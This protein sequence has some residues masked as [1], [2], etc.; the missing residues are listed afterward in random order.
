MGV[1]SEIFKEKIEEMIQA[2]RQAAK[3]E[4]WSE[5]KELLEEKFQLQERYIRETDFENL[6]LRELLA[7]VGAKISVQTEPNATFSHAGIFIAPSEISYVTVE[8]NKRFITSKY[9]LSKKIF[10]IDNKIKRMRESEQE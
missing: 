6:S 5:L 4:A 8:L 3:E 1:L 9:G 2:E 10:E 7:E